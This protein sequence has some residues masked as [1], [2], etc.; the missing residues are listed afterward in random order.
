[1][2]VV[3]MTL[4]EKLILIA[5]TYA[6]ARGIGRQR[7]STLVLNRGATLDALAEGRSDITTGTF[8][9]A[10]EWFSENW[11]DALA[12][13]DAVARPVRASITEAAE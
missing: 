8:E 6:K 11:P 1:M 13:P 5:D 4:R 12:W 7:V 10:L 3:M 9:K 2:F